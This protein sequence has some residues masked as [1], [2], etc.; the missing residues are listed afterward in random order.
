MNAHELW[1][2]RTIHNIYIMENCDL[3]QPGEICI[4]W[5]IGAE[6]TPHER[7]I[8]GNEADDFLE[9]YRAAPDQEHKDLV[10]L[11][12]IGELS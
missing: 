4:S 8:S 10:A 7:I 9:R 11:H 6:A 12:M 1:Q 3:L 5:Y 2:D